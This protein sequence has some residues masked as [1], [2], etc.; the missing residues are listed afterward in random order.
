MPTRAD[1]W[2]FNRKPKRGVGIQNSVT[3]GLQDINSM[4]ITLEIVLFYMF[5]FKEFAASILLA[6]ALEKMN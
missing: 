5:I 3:A 6:S 2:L 1:S 4:C